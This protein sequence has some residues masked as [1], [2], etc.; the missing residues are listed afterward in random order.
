[1]NYKKNNSKF[2]NFFFYI[3]NFLLFY[4]FN[5][6]KKVFLKVVASK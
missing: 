3:K 5:I 2:F 4:L 6:I 1:M